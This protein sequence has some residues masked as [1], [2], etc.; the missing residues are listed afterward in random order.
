[1]YGTLFGVFVFNVMWS[2]L[3]MTSVFVVL[4]VHQCMSAIKWS[5]HLHLW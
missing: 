4:C 2:E 3:L 5:V 1:M